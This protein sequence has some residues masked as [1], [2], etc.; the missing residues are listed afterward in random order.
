MFVS[1]EARLAV[2]ATVAHTRL[3]ELIRGS[4]LARASEAAYGE[5]LTGL[6]RAGPASSP[7]LTPLVHARFR[8]P[9]T[10]NEAVVL[11]LRW[12]VTGPGGVLFP[13]LDADIRLTP[14]GDEVTVLKLDGSYRPPLGAIGAVLDQAAMHR[15][16]TTTIRSFVGSIAGALVNPAL[17]RPP[18]QAVKQ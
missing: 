12:E 17:A 14:D 13:V 3:S 6:I 7:A 9:L 15:L 16:A 10:R 2:S 5:G 1:E 11:I 18:G 4:Q 8:E